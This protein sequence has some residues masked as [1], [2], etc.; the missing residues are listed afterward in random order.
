MRPVDLLSVS[1]T[2]TVNQADTFALTL[3][4]RHHQLERFPSGEELAWIDDD[5]LKAGTEV[6]IEMGYVGNLAIRLVGTIRAATFSFSESGLINVRVD[7]QSLYS[8]MFDRRR[9]QPFADKTDSASRSRSPATWACSLWLT[10]PA[11]STRRSPLA[12]KI[13][14]QFCRAAQSASTMS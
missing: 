14:Q 9:R 7:G 10:R 8:K 13:A 12:M 4:S 6:I 3:R 5:G 11:S 1:I 2:E